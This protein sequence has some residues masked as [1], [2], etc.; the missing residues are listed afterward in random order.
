LK[1]SWDHYLEE[2]GIDKMQRSDYIFEPKGDDMFAE[3]AAHIKSSVEDWKSRKRS[4]GKARE[5]AWSCCDTLSNHSN[6]FSIFPKG[7][8]YSS[9]FCGVLKTLVKVRLPTSE[10]RK[11]SISSKSDQRATHGAGNRVIN[12]PDLWAL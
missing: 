9:I 8:P 7:N 4:F 2:K 5:Y 1:A 3:F 10:F 12:Y 11:V 6:F